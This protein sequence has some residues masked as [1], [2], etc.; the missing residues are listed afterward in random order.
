[1]PVAVT[2]MSKSSNDL[3]T[4]LAS[5]GLWGL[6]WQVFTLLPATLSLLV[7]PTTSPTPASTYP[8][9]TALFFVFLSLSGLG[10]WTYNLVEQTIVQLLVPSTQRAEFSGVEMAFMSAAEIC[11]WGITAILSQPVQFKGVACSGFA[12]ITAS[13]LLYYSWVW[14]RWGTIIGLQTVGLGI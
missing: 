10:H 1:M 11:R 4:P 9:L 13:I 2:C 7:L 5:V 8:L 12:V 3:L 6:N 14:R